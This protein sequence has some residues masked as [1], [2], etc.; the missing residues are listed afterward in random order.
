MATW[1]VT[2][3]VLEIAD[4]DARLEAT[5]AQIYNY[6][7]KEAPGDGHLP[8]RDAGAV[9]Q[10][11]FSGLPVSLAVVIAPAGL[12]ND[13]VGFTIR[14]CTQRAVNFPISEAARNC[15]HVVYEGIW[16]P[17]SHANRE[18]I[19][20]LLDEV[21]LDVAAGAFL[22]W[23]QYLAFRK[24]AAGEGPVEDL[25]PDD[26]SSTRFARDSDTAG[27]EGIDATL[28]PYQITAWKWL[29]FLMR[30][31]LG[32]VLADPMGSGKTLAVISALR[33][34]GGTRTLAKALIIVPGTLLSNWESEIEKFCPDFKTYRH[35]GPWR[36]GNP[37]DLEDF[38]VVLASYD[39]ARIDVGLLTN[40]KWQAVI[41]D[42]A[43][44]IRNPDAQRTQAVKKLSDRCKFRLAVTGTPIQN[45]LNDLWSIMDF[46]QPDYLGNRETFENHYADNVASAAELM[47]QVSPLMLRRKEEEILADLPECIDMPEII[48]LNP[49][50]ATAYLRVRDSI[51]ERYGPSASLVEQT[52]LRQFCAHPALLDQEVES[53]AVTNFSK[54]GRLRELFNEIFSQGEKALVFTAWTNM[55]DWIEN[56][57]EDDFDVPA[58]TIDGRR[59]IN[60]RQTLVNEFNAYDGPAVMV[61][62]PKSGGE[63][64]NITGANHVIL[65]NPEWNPAV[66]DQAI[67]RAHR[68][69]QE[70]T[71]YV[72]RLICCG[73]VEEVMDLRLQRKRKIAETAVIGVGGA[74]ED[75]V[76][77]LDALKRS[78]VSGRVAPHE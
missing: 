8:P 6:F 31:Q 14:A 52:K 73:T 68:R 76:D 24:V 78:P 67:K 54:F 43:H 48:D 2:G 12:N 4:G 16:Y 45:R 64:L 30:E 66:Q 37:K 50:E 27:P 59:A 21:G 5:T 28:R 22:T 36:T 7:V 58:G 35:Q 25:L 77:L 26:F 9:A 72:R 61:V 34:Q 18:S 19:A 49:E 70:R 53:S 74:K 40:V 44:N 57:A 15:G 51:I 23:K 38:D 41:L 3:D 56:I 46:V 65:Y 13:Q 20:S 71:V 39:T 62:Q 11:E 1:V 75:Q 32:G 55:I 10:L 29:C 60:E 63:G 69:G 33:D 17:I 42:E 47:P